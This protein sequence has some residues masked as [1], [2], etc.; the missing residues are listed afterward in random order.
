M[1]RYF[2]TVEKNGDTVVDREPFDDYE[3]AVLS[4]SQFYESRFGRC[5]LSLTTEVVNGKFAR[6]FAELNLPES[7]EVVDQI[8]KQRYSI[9]A[10]YSNAFR[11]DASYLFLIESEVGLLEREDD[12][13]VDE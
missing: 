3:E 2:V 9:A 11:Y 6:S 4:L 1:A 7:I 13:D 12:N 8:S 10:K 5:V